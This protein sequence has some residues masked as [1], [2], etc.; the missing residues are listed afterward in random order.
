MNVVKKIAVY[1]DHFMASIIEYAETAT[2]IK[3]INSEFN[4]FEKQE[5][6][7]KGESHLHN[8]DKN[9]QHEFYLKLCDELH[10]YESILLFGSTN[11]KAEFAY[12]LQTN[13]KFSDV[14]ITIKNTD[15]LSENEQL[16]FVNDCFYFT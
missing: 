14:E 12:V 5:I 10:N 9:R 2:V 7:Q 3:K 8:K 13:N 16:E 1:M 11:A 6:L 4:Y 15:K